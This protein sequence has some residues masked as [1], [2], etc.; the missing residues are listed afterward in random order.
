MNQSRTKSKITLIALATITL[1]CLLLIVS[2][3]EI[4]CIHKYKKQIAR[5]EHQIEE[6]QNAKDYYKDLYNDKLNDSGY[7][8]DDLIFEEE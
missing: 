1:V 8:D 2:V 3:V 6:L 4:V 5:Q 7:G